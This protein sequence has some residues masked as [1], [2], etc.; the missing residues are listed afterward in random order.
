MTK[1]SGVGPAPAE[2][3]A[4]WIQRVQSMELDEIADIERRIF[5]D[6]DRASLG[7]LRHAIQWRRRELAA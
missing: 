6:G 2:T 4:L 1:T 3:V 7:G 5:R